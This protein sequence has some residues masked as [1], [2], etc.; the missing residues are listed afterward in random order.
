MT[1]HDV[2]LIVLGTSIRIDAADRTLLL[3]LAFTCMPRE[4]KSDRTNGWTDGCLR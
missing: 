2:A 1:D 4:N 3:M